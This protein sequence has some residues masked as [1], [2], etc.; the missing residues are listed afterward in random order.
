MFSTVKDIYDELKKPTSSLN[1]KYTYSD[2]VKTK[3]KTIKM[4]LGRIWFNILMPKE[5]PLV[6]EPVTNKVTSRIISDLLDKF[7]PEVTS[8]TVTDLNREAFK[9]HSFEP[10]T[11]SD[12]DFVLPDEIVKMKAKRLDNEK[13]PIKFNDELNNIAE[14][15][16]EILKKKKSSLYKFIASGAKGKPIDMAVL[17]IARGSTVDMEGNVS[18]PTANSINDGFTLKEF[19]ENANQARN[20][21]Y[22]RSIGSAEPGALARDIAYANSNIMLSKTTD[23]K[24]KRYLQITVTKDLAASL[25]GRYYLNKSKVEVITKDN[26]KGLVGTDIKLRS[27]LYCT[28]KKGICQTCYGT[29]GSNLNQDHI[30]LLAA[31]TLNTQGLN[32]FAMKA[33]HSSS[34]VQFTETDL[35]KDLVR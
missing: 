12:E 14:R 1:K 30:G 19:Y 28:D 29:M 25:I 13:D 24:V 31:S 27:P 23:C 22:I 18:A 26:T 6:D 11:F 33:R 9:L 3:N 4:S 8:E 7:G 2:A 10:V 17:I 5:Y 34:V 20:G 16:I 15:Y 35:L 21:L 32:A